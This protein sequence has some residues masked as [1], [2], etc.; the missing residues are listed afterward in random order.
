MGFTNISRSGIHR[1]RS[2]FGF[3]LGFWDH[4]KL[5]FLFFIC[6]D[7]GLCWLKFVKMLQ[8]RS[9]MMPMMG[10]WLEKVS[11]LFT[12]W[13]FGIVPLRAF[14]KSLRVKSH[15]LR[16]LDDS[17]REFGYPMWEILHSILQFLKAVSRFL[18]VFP[19]N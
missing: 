17:L 16:F 9:F 18:I 12:E 19:I 13:G 6:I 5:K 8:K 10:L 7:L 2:S 11:M 3:I 4:E 15:S 1:F 14:G